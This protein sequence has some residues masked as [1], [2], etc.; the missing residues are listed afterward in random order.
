MMRQMSHTNNKIV[1][2]K[3]N[4]KTK[5]FKGSCSICGRNKPRVFTE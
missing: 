5:I 3:I 1:Y 4:R 2:E